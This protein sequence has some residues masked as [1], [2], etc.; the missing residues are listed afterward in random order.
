VR[1]LI[2]LILLLSVLVACDDGKN[3]K[4]GKPGT[5]CSVESVND[6]SLIVC[7]DG[8]SSFVP[9][10]KDS[11]PVTVISLY[12]TDTCNEVALCVNG[13]LY[14]FEK[15]GLFEEILLGDYDLNG[16]GSTCKFTVA[17]NCE[18]IP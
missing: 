10:G 17:D 2:I 1:N 9:N 11:T 5:S 13:K 16:H 6:G 18:V 7:T 4:L 8:T 12:P 14:G 3:G 15:N